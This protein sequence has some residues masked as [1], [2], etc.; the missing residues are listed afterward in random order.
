MINKMPVVVGKV[1][2]SGDIRGLGA[3]AEHIV[4]LLMDSL[5]DC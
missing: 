5:S 4:P 3:H 1:L 2:V